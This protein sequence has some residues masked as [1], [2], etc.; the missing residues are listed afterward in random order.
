MTIE[1]RVLTALRRE[2]P[3]R[4][5]VFLYLNPYVESWHTLD[6]SYADILKACEQYADVIYDWHF[7]LG[8]FHTAAEVPTE[9]R[10]L[11][12][13]QTEHGRHPPAGPIT[14]VAKAERRGG[15]ADKWC[16][17]KEPVG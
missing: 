2:Q 11:A 16:R 14:T 15:G 17:A 8:F 1:E 7:P 5:P 6:P 3:D 10:Q 12:D 4:V 13:G 9:S